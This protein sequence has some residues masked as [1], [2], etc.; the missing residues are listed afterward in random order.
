MALRIEIRYIKHHNNWEI[1]M[2][3]LDGG[4]TSTN[5]SQEEVLDE[6][7]DKMEELTVET[8]REG[9]NES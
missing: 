7:K 6:I 1:R 8:E 3:D 2:G 5:V 4:T 9:K